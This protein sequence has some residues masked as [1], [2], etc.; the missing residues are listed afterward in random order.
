M[1]VPIII[2]GHPN[3]VFRPQAFWKTA[4][5]AVIPGIWRSTYTS[6]WAYSLLTIKHDSEA[7]WVSRDGNYLHVQEINQCFAH[8]DFTFPKTL[9][10]VGQRSSITNEAD[11]PCFVVSFHLTKMVRPFL[12]LPKSTRTCKPGF[13]LSL[14]WSTW[15][16]PIPPPPGIYRVS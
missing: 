1:W 3:N 14:K 13:V 8:R 11:E 15:D 6:L 9:S 4:F 12:S 2:D 7:K 16:S 10:P 5:Y